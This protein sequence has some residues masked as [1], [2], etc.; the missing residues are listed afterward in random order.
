MTAP[1][2]PGTGA[3]TGGR[4]SEPGKPTSTVLPTSP[5][6]R[7]ALPGPPRPGAGRSG[8]PPPRDDRPGERPTRPSTGRARRARLALKRID[9]WS[10]FL[11]SL[12]ASLFAGVALVVAVGALYTILSSLG[13][14]TSVNE[15]FGEVTG[16]GK[17]LFTASRFVGGAAILAAV[18]VVLLTLLATLGALLYNVC[19]SFTGGIEVTLGERD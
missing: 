1:Q 8:A 19:A 5:L 10:V 9:P 13:V 17:P 11:F 2:A 14:V 7:P 12:L 16:E 6:R 15:L 3:T 18:N 4:A